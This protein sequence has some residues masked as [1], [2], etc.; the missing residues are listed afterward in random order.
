VTIVAG[1]VISRP[2]VGQREVDKRVSTMNGSKE[3][4]TL[5]PPTPLK[6]SKN[7]IVWKYGSIS[8]LDVWIA[9][10]AAM[11]QVSC[12]HDDFTSYQK[13]DES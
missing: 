2:D 7:P 13:Y 12:N 3:K 11:V 6:L 8:Q 5:A 9:N 1:P 10:L 4:E